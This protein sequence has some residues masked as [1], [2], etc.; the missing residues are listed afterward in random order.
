MS[1]PNGHVPESAALPT[2]LI[3]YSADSSKDKISTL[4]YILYGTL[5]WDLTFSAV[6]RVDSNIF[7]FN[8][9]L[10]G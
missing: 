7:L 10:M 8:L 1:L 4:F 9:Y 6:S 5:A 3:Y 2:C